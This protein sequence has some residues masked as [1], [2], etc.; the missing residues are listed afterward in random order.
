MPRWATLTIGGFG[1][2]LT[3]QQL[4]VAVQQTEIA[5]DQSKLAL[6]QTT[7]ASDES[8]KANVLRQTRLVQAHE[9]DFYTKLFDAI[10]EGAPVGHTPRPISYS[11][12]HLKLVENPRYIGM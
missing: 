5:V 7:I 8:R 9:R 10:E 6:E 3:Y 1:F 4:R 2:G 12:L 11:D